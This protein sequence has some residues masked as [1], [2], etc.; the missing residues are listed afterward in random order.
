MFEY[1]I[2]N[3]DNSV[4]MEYLYIKRIIDMCGNILVK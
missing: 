2:W 1:K 4:Y 3:I